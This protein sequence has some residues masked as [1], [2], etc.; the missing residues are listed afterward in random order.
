M[1]LDGTKRQ[2]VYNFFCVR[3]EGALDLALVQAR[4]TKFGSIPW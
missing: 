4:V 3:L 1:Y 2:A